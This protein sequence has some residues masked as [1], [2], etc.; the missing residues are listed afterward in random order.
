MAPVVVLPEQALG[1]APEEMVLA[2]HFR[3]YWGHSKNQ[4][5]IVRQ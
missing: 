1:V 5:Q 3:P 4:C 2:W